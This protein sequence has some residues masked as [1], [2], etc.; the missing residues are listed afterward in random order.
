MVVGVSCSVVGP[1]RYERWGVLR[2]AMQKAQIL[3][4]SVGNFVGEQTS[5]SGCSKRVPL[6]CRSGFVKL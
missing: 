6:E 3:L 1:K 2:V 4:S 5:K